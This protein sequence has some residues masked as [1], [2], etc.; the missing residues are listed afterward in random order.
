MRDVNSVKLLLP[1]KVCAASEHAP[2]LRPHLPLL[3]PHSFPAGLTSL[4]FLTHGKHTSVSGP[5]HSLFL[6]PG[7][8]LPL[9]SSWLSP[10]D[11]SGSARLLQEAPLTTLSNSPHPSISVAFSGFLLFCGSYYHLAKLFVYCLLLVSSH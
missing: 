9:I 8:L 2:L 5:L 10:P 6:I 7:M 11:P 1:F 3:S 4:V